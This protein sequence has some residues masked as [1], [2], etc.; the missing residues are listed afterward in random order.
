M[1]YRDHTPHRFARFLSLGIFFAVCCTVF[2]ARLIYY[3]V[4]VR[5]TYSQP[6]I[7]TSGNVRTVKVK[8]QRGNI[9]D[10]NGR[11]LVTNSYSYNMQIEFGAL[12]EDRDEVHRSLLGALEAIEACGA[13]R[14]SSYS[15]FEG[16]Y[17]ELTYSAEAL[18][19]SGKTHKKLLEILKSYYVDSKKYSYTTAEEAFEAV[20]AAELAGKIAEYYD[21]VT[22][23][24]DGTV[25][26]SFT[27]EEIGR[28]VALRFDMEAAGYGSYSPYL[29][30][31][32]ADASLISYVKEH[33]LTGI[34]FSAEATR[35]YL[36]PGT[37]AHILGTVGVI[38]AE[39]AD[40]YTSQGYPLN[41]LVGKSGC[42]YAFESYLRGTDGELAIIEDDGG[43]VIGTYWVTEPVAGK[44][45]YLTID[46]NVQLAAESALEDNIKSVGG[47]ESGAV[48]ACDPNSGEILAIASYPTYDLTYF[49]R[50]YNELASA[51]GSPL[52]NRALSAYAPG[53]TFKVGV[54]LAALE[55]GKITSST[56]I[57]TEGIYKNMKCSHYGLSAGHTYCCGDINVC[58]AIEQSCNYFFAKLGDELGTSEIAK[59]ASL[60]GLGSATGIEIGESEG[61]LASNEELSFMAAIGQSDNLCTPLQVTQYV[62]AI[63]TGTRYA[64]HLLYSVNEYGTGEVSYKAN[65]QVLDTL[66]EHGISDAN[67]ATVRQGMR[68]VVH[69]ENG[70]SYVSDIKSSGA[71]Y[72]TNYAVA[73]KTG[74][75]EVAGQDAD[76]AWFTA[77]APFEDPQLSVTCLIVKGKTGGLASSA[78]REVFDAFFNGSSSAAGGT[79]AAG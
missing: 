73:G 16:D 19:A 41:A 32:G 30:V 27:D 39:D 4:A 44:D 20:S 74:T 61:R 72:G 77:Y 33:H 22:V 65:A 13:T 3:Q 79:G 24:K 21:I 43:A 55:T 75:A 34:T 46:L 50:D 31:S 42:E 1:R 23:K 15:I 63:A 53:S 14:A 36:Y 57:S 78:V 69:G 52:L 6:V 60:L 5:D 51:D 8:A 47:A 59:Y 62:S 29:L 38:Y 18:D 11:V 68:D 66:A 26:T 67:L 64:A 49:N 45:V 28:L 25:V 2:A 71:F 70:S 76:N 7:S 12:P 37:V 10:R 17:P 35:K 58:G 40:Y 9:C 56:V 54:A 48:V